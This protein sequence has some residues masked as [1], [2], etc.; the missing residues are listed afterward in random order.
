MVLIS[1]P[2]NF[3]HAVGSVK[4]KKKKKKEPI[5]TL[6]NGD[7]VAITVRG[8]SIYDLPETSQNMTNCRKAK[9]SIG[10]SANVYR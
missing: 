4:K 3:L 2:E 1:G 7:K 5:Q 6:S 8:N 9:G 10:C